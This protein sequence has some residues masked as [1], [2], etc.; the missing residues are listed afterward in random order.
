VHFGIAAN[1]RYVFV[2]I[3]DLPATRH[4]NG[5]PYADPPRPGLYA[6]DLA[7][8][9]IA[10]SA[11]SD[12][13]ACEGV[14]PCSI[15]YSQA[16][17]AT[18]GLVLG[19]GGDGWLRAF[20]AATGAVLWRYDTKAAVHTVNGVEASGGSFGGGNGPIADHGLLLASSG[21]SRPGVRPGN[22]LF[23]FEV[24]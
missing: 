11:P 23:A 5:Q 6:L 2:P 16:V 15:G 18:P 9:R 20:D 12:P 21:Y 24:K 7:T 17:T 19:G 8:G 3:N 4:D 22:V 10:W 14:K 1:A 13:K